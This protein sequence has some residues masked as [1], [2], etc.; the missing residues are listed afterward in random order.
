MMLSALVLLATLVLG[1]V[2]TDEGG[3]EEISD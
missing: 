1:Q 3:D 2:V